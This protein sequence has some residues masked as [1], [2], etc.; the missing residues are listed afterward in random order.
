M[1][2][3][4][5]ATRAGGRGYWAASR[6]NFII[7][8]KSAVRRTLGVN[9]VLFSGYSLR[10]GGVTALISAGVPLP[11]L[12]GH[13]GWAAGSAMPFTYFDSSAGATATAALG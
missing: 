5:A 10:R 11:V 12:N 1:F 6:S 2:V 13:V 7:K 3:S 8:L 9:P 4:F